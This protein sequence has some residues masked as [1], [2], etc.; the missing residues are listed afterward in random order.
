MSTMPL[1][2]NFPQQMSEAVSAQPNADQTMAQTGLI[3]Q[4]TAAAA[5]EL[6][7]NQWFHHLAMNWQNTPENA[8]YSDSGFPEPSLKA[9]AEPGASAPETA[10]PEGTV[11]PETAPPEGTVAHGLDSAPVQPALTSA[12]PAAATPPATAGGKPIPAVTSLPAGAAAAA[13]PVAQALAA[14]KNAPAIDPNAAPGT[15][16]DQRTQFQAQTGPN[17]DPKNPYDVAQKL[18]PPLMNA[19]QSN[20]DPRI[21]AMGDKLYAQAVQKQ[22]R[23]ADGL[24]EKYKQVYTTPDDQ[25]FNK[26]DRFFGSKENPHPSAQMQADGVTP[27]QARARMWVGADAVR[28]VAELPMDTPRDNKDGTV[29]FMEHGR[30]AFGAGTVRATVGIT[31]GEHAQLLQQE[32]QRA[33]TW[34]SDLLRQADETTDGVP[35]YMLDGYKLGQQEAWAKSH[36]MP[37]SYALGQPVPNITAGRTAAPASQGNLVSAPSRVAAP[38]AP[39]GNPAAT[40]S[41]IQPSNI[42]GLAIAPAGT[43]ASGVSAAA[44]PAAPPPQNNPASPASPLKPDFSDAPVAPTAGG[45]AGT[46]RGPSATDQASLIEY[47]SKTIPETNKQANAAV[48]ASQNDIQLA[49]NVQI[50]LKNAAHGGTA[51]K[52]SALAAVLGN[53]KWAQGI[54]GDETSSSLLKSVTGQTGVG[55]IEDIAHG[56]VNKGVAEVAQQLSVSPLMTPEALKTFASAMTVNAQYEGQKWGPHYRAYKA[57]PKNDVGLFDSYYSGPDKYPNRSAY[58]PKI[59]SGDSGKGGAV[60]TVSS[61]AQARALSPGTVFMS[62]DGVRRVR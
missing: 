19:L 35:R 17:F 5:E 27:A 29:T 62:P 22:Q 32:A 47:K 33:A 11:A 56:R 10:P 53:P 15:I 26:I 59:M 54:L 14:G 7:Y 41:M 4:Q 2:P 6:K 45:G 23:A 39:G 13:A 44:A 40:S 30:E 38:A 9:K 43:P 31:P 3:Q 51:E 24:I 12:G 28:A 52:R 58:D 34:H 48:A 42:P 61:P 37:P 49:K 55:V 25:I 18:K 20:P 50:T 16:D 8:Q 57:D 36:P 46:G 60:V 1:M 21:S